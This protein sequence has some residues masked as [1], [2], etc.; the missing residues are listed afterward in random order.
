MCRIWETPVGKACQAG[1]P[2]ELTVALPQQSAIPRAE[3]VRRGLMEMGRG[4]E[5]PSRERHLCSLLR[6]VERELL[7][8]FEQGSDPGSFGFLTGCSGC[9]VKGGRNT[10]E[11][12]QGRGY[13]R[14]PSK[15]S[16]DAGVGEWVEVA[17][18]VGEEGDP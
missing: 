17:R 16:W 2:C 8:G 1:E 18:G 5:K 4:Q 11:I 7:K 10:N 3:Q 6:T 12:G 15:R 9:S 14:G 13:C